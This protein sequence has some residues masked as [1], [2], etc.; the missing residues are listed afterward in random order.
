MSK[1]SIE[2]LRELLFYNIDKRT[3]LYLALEILKEAYDKHSDDLDKIKE[4]LQE[5]KV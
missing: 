3:E 4:I 5:D 1:D 2:E